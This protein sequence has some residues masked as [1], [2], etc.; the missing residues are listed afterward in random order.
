MILFP[1]NS[2][3]NPT[4]ES[5]SDRPT[6]STIPTGFKYYDTTLGRF[7]RW[8]GNGWVDGN[9]NNANSTYSGIFLKDLLILV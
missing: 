5:S 2:I 3:R 4:I 6:F 7:I 1:V 9:N 8:N